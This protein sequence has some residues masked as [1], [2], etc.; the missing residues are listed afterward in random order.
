[1]KGVIT[2]PS[3]RALDALTQNADLLSVLSLKGEVCGES[4]L[5][6]PTQTTLENES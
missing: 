5:E 6:R 1:M 2:S 4:S 3:N